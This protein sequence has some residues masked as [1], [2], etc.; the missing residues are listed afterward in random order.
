MVADL[1]LAVCIERLLEY[2]N[3]DK[4]YAFDADDFSDSRAWGAVEL[5]ANGSTM[6]TTFS[7]ASASLSS[8]KRPDTTTRLRTMRYC[9]ETPSSMVDL[10]M[11]PPMLTLS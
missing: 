10:L 8:K 2:A 6:T 11:P 5:F 4:R 9:G 1:R 7:C 3:N